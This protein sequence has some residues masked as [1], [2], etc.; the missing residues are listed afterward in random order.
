MHGG[1]AA[2]TS[3]APH[4]SEL[5]ST[6]MMSRVKPCSGTGFGERCLAVGARH[7]DCGVQIGQANPPQEEMKGP[8][9]DDLKEAG[10]RFKGVVLLG[11]CASST[12]EEEGIDMYDS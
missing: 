11:W 9:D 6:T 1:R 8:R 4:E 7:K 5:M 12:F 10:S 3:G 2:R